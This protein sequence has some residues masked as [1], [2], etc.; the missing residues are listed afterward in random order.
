LPPADGGAATVRRLAAAGDGISLS[1]RLS[2]E[3]AARLAE[4][5]AEIGVPLENLETMDPWFAAITLAVLEYRKLGMNPEAGV[6]MTL[7]SAARE[8]G[9]PIG[10]L[11]TFEQ[12]MRFFE[13]MPM[14]QQVAM[15]GDTLDQL[16]T[17]GEDINALVGDWA[18][19]D[20]E[21]FAAQINAGFA[22]SPELRAI[23]LVD[24]NRIWAEWIDARLDEPG[25]VF[26]AVGAGH[27][28]GEGSVQSF[29]AE[30]D[31]ETRRL[32]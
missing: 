30:R 28:A 1:D 4:A 11:E 29:L 7:M 14:A 26:L 5:F 3:Q 23:L 27:L 2:D 20:V 31:I 21:G 32:D 12:Q 9:K 17:I 25:T 22:D 13:D 18:A 15:L 8:A 24:R 19:G 10:D 6:E 16:A